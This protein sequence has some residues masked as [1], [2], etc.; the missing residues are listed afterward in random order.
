MKTKKSN[1]K[2]L[3]FYIVLIAAIIFSLSFMFSN[4]EVEQIKY[5]Q[6]VDYFKND[7]VKTFTID[8]EDYITM[9]VYNIDE[10]RAI[11]DGTSQTPVSELSTKTIGY[12]L[13][14]L[15]LFINDCGDFY[16]TNANLTSYDIEPLTTYPWW[17]SFLPY[18]IV[19]VIFIVLWVVVMKQA[20][21]A[22]GGAG[23]INSFG[24]ARVT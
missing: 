5:S 20:G 10:I 6:V 19:I 7:A 11:A 23:K 18:I 4:Q 3:I 12:Q 9:E 21:G 8:Q 17:V 22:G 15:N 2:V 14:S 16:T 13:Q 24:K 1:F